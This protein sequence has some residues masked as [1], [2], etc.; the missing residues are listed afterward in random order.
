MT[1]GLRYDRAERA[2][3]QEA[4]VLDLGFAGQFVFAAEGLEETFDAILPRL[5]VDWR[6]SD[7]L[8]VYASAARGWIPGGFNLAATSASLIAGEDFSRYGAETLWSYEVGAK[9]TF[10]DGRLLLSGAA[11]VIQADDW[12]EY[13]VL[14]N[15]QGQAVSTNLITS[16]AAITSRGFEIEL[17]GRPTDTLDLTASLGVVESEY[18]RYVFS[19]AQDFTGNKVKLVPEFDASISA[20][21]RPWRGL[22]LRGEAN[23]TG[24]T[25]LNA[26]NL[27][28]QDAVV[29]LNAQIGWEHDAWTA[30]LYVEN[31]TDELVYTSSAYANFAFGFDGTYYAGVGQPRVVGLQLSRKW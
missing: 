4:G 15:A 13:N 16:N 23:A 6:P 30:R 1:G 25:P 21:W 19:A 31:L 9:Y 10:M 27:A 22:F 28:W 20:T 7:D 8:L 12:Q 14:T 29:L 26:E 2:K 18:D 17:V 24:D 3:R 11:F 5:A